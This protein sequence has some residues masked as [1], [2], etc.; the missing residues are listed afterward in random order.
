MQSYYAFLA[1]DLANDRA[2]DAREH[3][4][5]AL[6]AAGAPE[7]PS[8]ARRALAHGLAAVSRWSAAAVRQLDDAVADDLRRAVAPGK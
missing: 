7:R 6:V 4:R 1:L 5:S 3:R 2:R 8:F